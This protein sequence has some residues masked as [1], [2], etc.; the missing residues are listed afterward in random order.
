MIISPTQNASRDF[1][2]RRLQRLRL[3]NEDYRS[4]L[5]PGKKGE[6]IFD[7]QFKSGMLVTLSHPTIS[8]LRGKPVSRIW[9][10]DYDAMP[11]NVEGEGSPFDLAFARAKTFR[12][13]AMVVVESSPGREVENA[14]WTKST[15][16]EAPPSKGVLALYNRGDRRRW[17]WQCVSCKESFE[18]SFSLLRP[19]PSADIVEASETCYLPCPHCGQVYYHDDTDV[20]GKQ[21]M[22]REHARWL[23]EGERWTP[24]G[25][26]GQKIR[27]STAS[28][29]L[30]GPA[31]TYST[32]SFLVKRFLEAEKEFVDTGSEDSLRTTVNT[33]QAEPY[34]PKAASSELVPEELRA[35][36]QDLGER[37]VPEGV[38]FLVA[39][40][41]V[42]KHRF[43]VQVHGFH[44]NGDIV[45]I[46]RFQIR[47]SRRR[48]EDGERLWVSPFTHAEDWDVLIDEVLRK[49]YPLNDESG[50]AMQIKRTAIDSG[51]Q[52]EATPNAYAF[53][54]RLRDAG[55]G[56]HNRVRLIKGSPDRNAPRVRLSY[57]DAQRKDK[58]AAARGDVPV[59]LLNSNMLK[60]QVYN[61]LSRTDVGGR[62]AFPLWLP[63]TFYA[64]LTAEVKTSKGWEN[65]R[66]L[67]NEAWDLLCYA[68]SQAIGPD[69]RWEMIDWTAPPAWAA[70]WDQNIL[71]GQGEIRFESQAKV[72]YDLS[73]LGADLA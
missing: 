73:K 62:V 29:W 40:V 1:S 5:M 18:P 15:P 23:G 48:D 14:R 64:E 6:N 34:V 20:P 70:P 55:G 19:G 33:D 72:E 54:R 68:L 3:D 38:R 36:Q 11:D 50:R 60:D 32:W 39:A 58:L 52:Q 66:K 37:C 9:M 16:H 28:F 21:T 51:G 8:E 25:V 12:R 67:R 17:H 49:T 35:R 10:T 46:D 43:E 69:I 61:M 56:M 30:K 24:D 59:D 4:R 65:P 53:W 2:I 45:I 42:Q 27:T 71:V 26:V 13:N 63:D 31:A 44:E 47:K 41:D 57:P 7:I 22:N